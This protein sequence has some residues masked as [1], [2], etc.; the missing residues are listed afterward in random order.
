MTW[1]RAIICLV[2]LP[3]SAHAGEPADSRFWA[4]QPR[5]ITCSS[6]ASMHY[7]LFRPEIATDPAPLGSQPDSLPLLLL[8]HSITE[9]GSDNLAPYQFFRP[10]LT[11][12]F[13]R[14]H[15]CFIVIPQC[16]RWKFWWEQ[17]PFEALNAIIPALLKE[18]PQIDP[19]RIYISGASLGGYATYAM[20]AENPGLFAAAIPISGD[21]S[22]SP[23]K[24]D[25]IQG[26]PIWIFHGALD[27]RVPIK[28]DRELVAKLKAL[29]ASPRY[30]EYP[31]LGHTVWKK[32]YAEPQLWDWVFEQ[33]RH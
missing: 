9:R 32:A 12:A 3:L 21:P 23:L 22:P 30:T 16:P 6:G 18:F 29:G 2:F 11:E 27:H 4:Y 5:N 33:R 10:Y 17:R 7:R 19:T 24:A 13:Y 28:G 8:L 1:I 26:L 20:L 31:D 25:A 15:P 14:K